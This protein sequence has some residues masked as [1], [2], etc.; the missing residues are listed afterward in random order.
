MDDL[1]HTPCI[2]LRSKWY[3]LRNPNDLSSGISSGS[4]NTSLTS[5][6]SQKYHLAVVD[7]PFPHVTQFTPR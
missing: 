5:T 3:C 1:L 2:I 4:V 7:E 6:T